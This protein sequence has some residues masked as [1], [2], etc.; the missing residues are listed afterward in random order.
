ME[1]LFIVL[2]FLGAFG[3]GFFCCLF[4]CCCV[5][6]TANRKK[7]GCVDHGENKRTQHRPGDLQRSR[8]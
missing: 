6:I 1:T 8:D 5:W 2:A 7:K 4:F 3:A